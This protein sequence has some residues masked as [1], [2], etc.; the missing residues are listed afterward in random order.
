MDLDDSTYLLIAQLHLQDVD[1]INHSHKGKA[2]QD[3]P[4]TDEEYAFQLQADLVKSFLGDM[5]DKRMAGILG[6]VIDSDLRLVEQ[7]TIREQ[8]E[9]DD[10]RYATALARGEPLPE[11]SDAQRRVENFEVVDRRRYGGSRI[12]TYSTNPDDVTRDSS[13]ATD[14]GNAT[15]SGSN[16]TQG[17]SGRSIQPLFFHAQLAHG[18]S[19]TTCVVCVD[20]VP[21]QRAFHAAACGH[22]YCRGCLVDLVQACTRDESL[23][24]LRCCKQNL[25]L[26]GVFPFLDT[27]TRTNF[28][29]KAREFDVQ[30]D[31][32][33]YCTN[34]VC[35]TFLGS[36]MGGKRTV[37]CTTC[38]T[39]VCTG[40]KKAS[41]LGE[42][43]D[44]E[45]FR[46]LQALAREEGWQTCPGC[47]RIINLHHGCF[48][49]T[50]KCGTQFCYLCAAP[51]KSCRCPQ[52]D[53][54]RL[55]KSGRLR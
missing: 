6:A 18:L 15:A 44:N 37:T 29:I 24:P 22:Y 3:S 54:G 26:P 16:S 28:Q 43:T 25:S 52:W 55:I 31:N 48:H 30:P 8:A 17:T 2:K 34:P 12:L 45:A 49:M 32:R 20:R 14:N 23:Y 7:I 35:S 53:E 9:K 1:M 4:L 21:S 40:C 47:R 19:S 51:W 5:E 33:L 42:C 10:H 41:H 27:E 50:C 39:T 36:N 11:K 13:R 38:L 46:Q